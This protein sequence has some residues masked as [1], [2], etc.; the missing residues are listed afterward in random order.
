MSHEYSL[1]GWHLSFF[2]GK[3]RGYLNFKGIPFND[4]QVNA[5]DL[6]YRIPKKTGATVMPVVKTSDG[7]WLQD[8]T[9]IVE[10]IEKRHPEPSAKPNT[11]KQLIASMLIE[12]WCDEWWIPIA[13]HYR[14]SYPENFELFK[15]DSGKA[16]LP[17]APNFVRKPFV[18]RIANML[19]G[20]LPNVGV[21]PE[22]F[23]MMEAWTHKVLNILE[24]HFAQHDF[25]FG[26]K[27]TIADFALVGPMYG[28]LNRDPSPKRDLLDVRPHLQAWVNRV[29][30]GKG[31][32]GTLLANDE[33]P[34]TLTPIF[35][36]IFTEFYPMIEA[37][38][39]KLDEHVDSD[40]LKKGDT[41]ARTLGKVSFPMAH[42]QFSR[43]GMPYS[44]WMVQRIVDQ[45]EKL[46]L[47]DQISVAEWLEG[48]GYGNIMNTY[49]GP[50][51]QRD[52][53][54][55]RLAQYS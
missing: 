55:T 15:R 37:I 44:V 20:F 6:L 50:Q 1:Y 21:I 29:H 30:S 17:F 36:T 54:Q 19:R 27:P 51:L 47:L 3:T 11:P 2:T 9:M 45:Y 42:G 22:Q 10:E 40:N 52:K 18:N 12:A 41:V 5:F 13:M 35:E 28:H 49:L 53:L 46:S 7:Q 8:S 33:V 32:T 16:L 24:M 25:L 38:V 23:E 43:A 4:V 14:W 31:G 48:L 26:N 34:E 39:V